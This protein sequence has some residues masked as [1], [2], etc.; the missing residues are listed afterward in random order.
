MRNRIYLYLA[1]AMLIFALFFI[2]YALT[3]PEASFSIPISLTYLFYIVYIVLMV[4]LFILFL[5]K[6][7]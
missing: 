1:L 3:H 6:K 7:S 2:V 5:K 4:I